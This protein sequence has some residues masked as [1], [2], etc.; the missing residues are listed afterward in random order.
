MWCRSVDIGAH[1]ARWLVLQTLF[2]TARVP[3]AASPTA[4][5]RMT[6]RFFLLTSRHRLLTRGIFVVSKCLAQPAAAAIWGAN[7][8]DMANA[9][10]RF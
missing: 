6:R 4:T 3:T 7:D 2:M 8:F 9:A 10:P 5:R 1:H